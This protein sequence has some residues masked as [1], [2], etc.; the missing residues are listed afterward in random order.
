MD[1]IFCSGDEPSLSACPF[2]GW[3]VHDCEKNEV[4]GVVC[5]THSQ[6]EDGIRRVDIPGEHQVRR[7]ARTEVHDGNDDGGDDYSHN[8]D[9]ESLLQE[10]RQTQPLSVPSLTQEG[11]TTTRTTA[12]TGER[13]FNANSVINSERDLEVSSSPS[14][15]PSPSTSIV[16]M[17]M[18]NEHPYHQST[19]FLHATST[20]PLSNF[21]GVSI[22]GK[23][24]E[25]EDDYDD[26]E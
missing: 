15:L 5:R 2:N 9:R 7:E 13:D 19:S 4:A 8:N 11:S 26:E 23:G 12:V 25:F 22:R 6:Q 18:T 20:S 21:H 1:N 16:H 10:L 3:K 24:E 17:L 14:P